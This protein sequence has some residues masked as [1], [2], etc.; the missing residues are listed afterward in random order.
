[1]SASHLQLCLSQ[2]LRLRLCLMVFTNPLLHL[3]FDDLTEE[4]FA[5]TRNLFLWMMPSTIILVLSTW[6]S[7]VA[8]CEWQVQSVEYFGSA[9]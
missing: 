5:L 8:Q 3:I 4:E 7:G 2:R 1:M 6:M 9:I